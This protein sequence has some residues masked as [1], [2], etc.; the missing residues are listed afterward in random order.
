MRLGPVN[1][2][3][4]RRDRLQQS[5]GGEGGNVSKLVDA[6]QCRVDKDLGNKSLMT[7]EFF[8]EWHGCLG[9]IAASQRLC[10]CFEG[11]ALRRGVEEEFR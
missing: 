11:R 9:D 1:H 10:G 6:L 5:R 4:W 7:N 2:S 8:S 3:N